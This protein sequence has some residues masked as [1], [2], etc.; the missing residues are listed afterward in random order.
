MQRVER[1]LQIKGAGHLFLGTPNLD[2]QKRQLKS[3]DGADSTDSLLPG[4]SNI[5]LPAQSATA[6]HGK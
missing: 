3:G 4:M 6:L 2:E 1:E 5:D